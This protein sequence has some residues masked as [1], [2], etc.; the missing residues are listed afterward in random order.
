MNTIQ[1]RRL[2][3]LARFLRTVP[4]EKFDIDSWYNHP[5]Q[6]R[7]PN[8][9]DYNYE[10][11]SAKKFLSHCGTT[12]CA[13]GWA[14]VCM[15]TIF[16]KDER[17]EV[18]CLESGAYQGMQAAQD[19]FGITYRESM[20]LFSESGYYSVN[21]TP[22]VVARRIEQFVKRKEKERKQHARKR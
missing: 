13:M 12:A 1:K 10:K 20:H 22:K 9:P 6:H 4:K 18:I 3:K 2:L 15:P 21:P 19:G 17:D 5:F 16:R 7:K 14:A 11:I 8:G